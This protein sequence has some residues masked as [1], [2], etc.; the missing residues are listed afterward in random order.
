MEIVAI[1]P[2]RYN[3]SRFPGKPLVDICG[4][5]MIWWVYKQVKKVKEINDIIVATDDERIEKVCHEYS[6]NVYMTQKSHKTS[7]ERAYEVAQNK[8]ADLYIVI[9]GDEPLIEPE[10]ISKIIPKGKIERFYVGNL[11]T[12][13][14]RASEVVDFTNIKVVIDEYRNAIYFSRS[15]IP[16]PKASLEYDY[17][18]HVGVLAYSIEALEFFASSTPSRN[19]KI[20]DINELRFI[21]YGKIIH[22]T[23]V[24]ANSL[25]VDTPKDVEV[26][27]KQISQMM[28]KGEM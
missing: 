6:M 2:A 10:V 22:M 23:E 4:K 3:S 28:Y 16:Y 24:D 12:K 7:T 19:E 15:P 9:N 26:V 14:K 17:Y 27:R 5:P 21:D 11:M 13:I 8:R 20:E 25:S 1:I 18:K